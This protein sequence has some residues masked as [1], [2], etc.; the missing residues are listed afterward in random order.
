MLPAV[1]PTEVKIVVNMKSAEAL[2]LKTPPS[3]L[4]RADE[5]IR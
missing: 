3:V 1:Q 4:A 2:G 5:M